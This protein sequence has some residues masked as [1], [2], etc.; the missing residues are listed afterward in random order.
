MQILSAIEEFI[1]HNAMM[2]NG[3]VNL[4]YDPIK[5]RHNIRRIKAYK[6]DTNVEDISLKNMCDNVNISSPVQHIFIIL[7]LGKKVYNGDMHK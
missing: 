3:T 7:K 5:I 1:Y 2:T 6:P 4:K